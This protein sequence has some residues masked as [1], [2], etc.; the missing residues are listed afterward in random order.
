MND[1]CDARLILAIV[2]PLLGGALSLL[3]K[4]LPGLKISRIAAPF[5]LAAAL[6]CVAG[7]YPAAAGGRRVFYH[8]GNWGPPYGISLVMDGAAWIGAVTVFLVAI[9]TVIYAAGE[10]KHAPV[11]FLCFQIMVAAMIGLILADDIFNMFVFLEI[12]A[13]CAYI[14]IACL[15]KTRAIVASLNYLFISSL[16][17]SLFL[18]G[19]FILYRLTG[20]LSLD[21]MGER[22]AGGALAAHPRNLAVA[23]ACLAAGLG[24]R[25]A[26]VPFHTWLPEAHAFAPHPVSAILSAV[27]IKAA[28]LALWR[29]SVALGLGLR[30]DALVW[31]GAVAALVG[32]VWALAQSDVKKLLAFHSISQMGYITAAFGAGTTLSMT[33][34]CY[35][36]VSHAL[37]K[38]LLFLSV[39]SVIMA[40]GKRDLRQLGGLGRKAAWAAIPFFAGAMAIAGVPPFNGFVSKQLIVESLCRHPAYPLVWTTGILTVASFI[41]LSGMFRGRSEPVPGETPG[42]IEPSVAVLAPLW[43]LAAACLL[44]GVAPNFCVGRLA[45]ILANSLPVDLRNIAHA[46]PALSLYTLKNIAGSAAVVVF[47][48]AAFLAVKSGPGNKA[49]EFIRSLRLGLQNS[50]LMAIG[51]FILFALLVVLRMF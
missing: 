51:G 38:S 12:L 21:A 8:L 26:I 11:F 39:G 47:G 40:T 7:L 5:S 35:H 50:L 19:V 31:I 41:K 1:A 15:K 4:S 34:S 6:A 48:F 46:A 29:V 49:V 23:M 3:E 17:V 10:K 14:L 28:F 2:I 25:A 24:V 36:I 20:T 27:M 44:T 45:A 43:L 42:I 9:A 30:G 22:L 32:V 37:F 16:G 13:L 33:A 18:V